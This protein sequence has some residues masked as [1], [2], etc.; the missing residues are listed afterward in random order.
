MS[1]PWCEQEREFFHVAKSSPV[2]PFSVRHGNFYSLRPAA[3]LCSPEALFSF[4]GAGFSYVRDC[5][6]FRCL[7]GSELEQVGVLLL[8]P[9]WGDIDGR[10]DRAGNRTSARIETNSPNYDSHLSDCKSHH[11]HTSSSDNARSNGRD[12]LKI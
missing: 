12:I 8:V 3:L 7:F 5:Q 1:W 10:L 11:G 2:F 9:F 6:L 4:L